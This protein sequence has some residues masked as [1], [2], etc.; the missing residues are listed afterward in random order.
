M[1]R[2]RDHTSIRRDEYHLYHNSPESMGY[3]S[4][5]QSHHQSG[6]Q[7]PRTTWNDRAFNPTPS[8]ADDR[9]QNQS[10][11]YSSMS[12]WSS[13]RP[14]QN[15]PF[16]AGSGFPEPQS[17]YAGDEPNTYA[18][19]SYQTTAYFGYGG[20]TAA[21]TQLAPPA[22]HLQSTIPR[23][24]IIHNNENA[25]IHSELAP[26]AHGINQAASQGRNHL[27]NSRGSHW[28]SS[29]GHNEVFLVVWHETAGSTASTASSSSTFTTLFH[30]KAY[31]T[32]R[33]MVVI[34]QN[35]DSCL[36]VPVHTYQKRGAS[37]PG[38]RKDAHVLI[39]MRGTDP[40]EKQN[41]YGL[42]KRPLMVDPAALTER[43]DSS[44][45]VHLDKIHTVEYNIKVKAVGFISPESMG[46][47]KQY[48][49]NILDW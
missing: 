41:K 35:K 25:P 23:S 26:I 28:I 14:N 38:I 18:H 40:T 13:T 29:P 2:R 47:L 44:S 6:D 19:Q 4:H 7:D 15:N 12:A 33:R 46:D 9:L 49:K 8:Y 11:E 30:E 39:H 48:V 5:Y 31:C 32:I 42:M 24:D 20:Y 37:K 21:A 36:C 10:R 27:M 34:K 43:L 1:S 3:P 22:N 45:V 17:Q 16:S